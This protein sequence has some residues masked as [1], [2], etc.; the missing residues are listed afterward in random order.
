MISYESSAHFNWSIK[1][2][3]C[4]W[5]LEWK[6]GIE[7]LRVGAVRKAEEDKC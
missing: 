7:G 6:V 1:A 5:G 4:D 3:A 2:R